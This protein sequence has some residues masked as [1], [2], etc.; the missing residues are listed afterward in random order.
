MKTLEKWL[1]VSKALE[2]EEFEK[3]NIR[4]EAQT[5]YWIKVTYNGRGHSTSSTY[6]H[7]LYD[8][9]VF[10]QVLEPSIIEEMNLKCKTLHDTWVWN[11]GVYAEF[12]LFDSEQKL[13]N[14]E[15]YGSSHQEKIRNGII[16]MKEYGHFKSWEAIEVYEEKIELLKEFENRDNRIESLEGLIQKLRKEIDELKNQ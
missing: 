14:I 13:R 2:V 5:K 6:T 7:K 8:Y 9:Q 16:Y 1:R 10:D 4:L 3:P 12:G 15:I 11:S